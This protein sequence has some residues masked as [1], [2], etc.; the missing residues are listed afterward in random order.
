MKKLDTAIKKALDWLERDQQE[1]GY[2]IGNLESNSCME[3]QWIMA[4]HFMRIKDYPEYDNVIQAILDEQ[5]DDGSWEIYHQADT[6]DINT[7]V[8][9]YAALKCAGHRPDMPHMK[10]ARA[11]ILSHGGLSTIRVFTKYWLALLGEW[12]WEHTPNLPPEIIFQPSWMPFSIY[13]FASWA[14]ATIMPLTLLCSSRPSRPLPDGQG[15]DELF[16]EGREN[17][18]FTIPR[19]NRGFCFESF[20]MFTDRILNIYAGLPWQ[21]FRGLAGKCVIEWIIRHQDADGIWGGIQPPTIYALMALYNEGYLLSHPVLSRCLEAFSGHWSYKKKNPDATYVN[22]SESLVWDTMLAVMAQADCGL[23]PADNDSM[24]K[25]IRWLSGMFL[26][27]P[28]DWQI[29]VKDAEPGA[30]AFERA[31][32][33]YPDVDDTAVALIVLSRLYP[34][35]KE[36]LGLK[37]QITLAFRWL[38]AMQSS[39]G[40]W[41]AFDRDNSGIL[42]T[43]IPFCDF[44]EALDPPSV[45]VTAHVLEAF[46]LLGMTRDDP[47]AKKAIR[48]IKAEQEPGGSWFGRWGV[49]HIY[50]TAA[51]LPALQAIGIDM[52]AEWIKR[53]ADWVASVQ[54]SD[55]GWGETCGSYMD[56]S[57]I[58][59][60]ESTASQTGWA[61][62]AL[63][64]TGSPQYIESVRR[65]LAWLA[66]T[67]LDNGTWDEP[68]YTGTGFPGY[69]VGERT[70]PDRESRHLDQGVELS[71]GFMI[72]YNLYRHYFPLMAMG[73]ARR[74]LARLTS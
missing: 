34:H 65:G 2:W 13:R 71:R 67:Q 10:K 29:Y 66:E 5:R 18:D 12:P 50:G 59:K 33:W 15:L 40:G 48:Y 32:T 9:C 1:E 53:A 14:R 36:N 54:N 49:N 27:T 4:M 30:W 23:L 52:N 6:G 42:V 63:V 45:D 22:A 43:K 58:G 56:Y 25:G 70:A 57:L 21:P 62:M 72:N 31:N 28:G 11:W 69:G 16:P 44:G 37:R 60:G 41:A 8:E 51:V 38:K 73:R 19:K 39:N 26:E 68:F 61:I 64:A 17:F 20:F 35:I 7:T 47:V 3:A 74:Y 24:M 46:G 55:G